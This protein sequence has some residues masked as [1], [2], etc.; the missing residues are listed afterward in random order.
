MRSKPF[1]EKVSK[2]NSTKFNEL[3]AKES[4]DSSGLK[5]VSQKLNKKK[6]IKIK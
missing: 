2:R 6:Q 1:N 5:K 3:C 4:N